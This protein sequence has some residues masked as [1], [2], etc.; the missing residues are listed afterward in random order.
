MLR[1]ASNCKARGSLALKRLPF[2][3]LVAP[4]LRDSLRRRCIIIL[5]KII[6]RRLAAPLFIPAL[7][8]KQE[9]FFIKN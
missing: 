7:V 8:A 9:E 4:L 5:I 6:I 2:Y 1:K 3:P